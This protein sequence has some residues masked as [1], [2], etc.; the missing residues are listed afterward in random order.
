MVRI[1]R[2]GPE[3]LHSARSPELFFSARILPQ[4]CKVE[5]CF[6]N[7]ESFGIK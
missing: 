6:S 5:A 7:S 3:K 1:F 2:A 4:A